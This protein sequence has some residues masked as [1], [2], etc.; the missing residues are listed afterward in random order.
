MDYLLNK[1][2]NSDHLVL[3]GGHFNADL[4]NMDRGPGKIVR[5]KN[6]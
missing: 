1:K 6:G 4:R 3:M 2:N 5:W